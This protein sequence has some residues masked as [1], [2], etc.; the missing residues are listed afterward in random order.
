MAHSL[1]MMIH[2]SLVSRVCWTLN[3][4]ELIVAFP[5]VIKTLEIVYSPMVI[6]VESKTW[7]P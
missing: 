3:L 6:I 5:V 4:V 2:T 1:I 7:I